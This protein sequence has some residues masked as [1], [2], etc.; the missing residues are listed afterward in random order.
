MKWNCAKC[1]GEKVLRSL[2]TYKKGVYSSFV[3][4]RGLIQRSIFETGSVNG[5]LAGKV[6]SKELPRQRNDFSVV[7][8]KKDGHAHIEIVT[9]VESESNLGYLTPHSVY[10]L[11][12]IIDSLALLWEREDRRGETKK[13]DKGREG[14]KRR[15]PRLREVNQFAQFWLS[16][17]VKI[18]IW[19]SPSSYLYLKCYALNHDT[20]N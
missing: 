8:M 2:R 3:H 9:K 20:K 19:Q 13:E 12:P 15:K 7:R 17:R 4:H 16:H 14:K 6:V 11:V 10:Y 5:I 18:Q 1:Q